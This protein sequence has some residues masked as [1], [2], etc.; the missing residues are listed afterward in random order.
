VSVESKLVRL[1][2]KELKGLEVVSIICI[3]S[4]F[5]TNG[6][7]VRVGNVLD[8]GVDELCSSLVKDIVVESCTE[9]VL[10]ESSVGKFCKVSKETDGV[11]NN[12]V[13][14]IK[15]ELCL[16]RSEGSLLSKYFASVVNEWSVV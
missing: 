3:L 2:D 10:V 13:V 15:I 16:K 5:S 14:S 8:L 6:S 11:E 1:F 4:L 7:G 9:T 12:S